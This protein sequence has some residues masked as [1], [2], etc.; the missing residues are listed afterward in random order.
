[1]SP[2][3]WIVDPSLRWPEDQGVSEVLGDWPGESRVFRPA[4]AP[5][6]G[7]GPQTGYDA[8]GV[9]VLGSA[10][11]VHDALPWIG[12][13]TSWLAPVLDGRHAIPVLGVCF[14]HQLIAHVA[15]GRVD[16]V[17]PDRGKTLGVD[18]VAVRGSRLYDDSSLH[19]VF[20]HREEVRVA[21]PDYRTVAWRKPGVLDGLEHA[22]LPVFTYQFHPEAR[23]EFAVRAGIDPRD[24]DADVIDGTRRLLSAFRDTVRRTARE[25]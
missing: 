19:V 20:S 25:A 6:D 5:G 15:G 7:P 14:G 4:L 10:A 2:R 8:D 23:D 11:S 3:L 21:P 24:I 18:E 17:R 9:V 22:R 16:W 1:V 12:E 13:L